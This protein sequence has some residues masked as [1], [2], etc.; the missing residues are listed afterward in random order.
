MGSKFL[1]PGA[2]FTSH[3]I[4]NTLADLSSLFPHHHCLTQD[5]SVFIPP[6]LAEKCPFVQRQIL[7][8]LHQF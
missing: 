5:F 6:A 2:W 1:E 3:V 7:I 8:G 4:E